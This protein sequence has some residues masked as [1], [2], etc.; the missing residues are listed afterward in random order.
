MT[1]IGQVI[2][3][4]GVIIFHLERVKYLERR[5][6]GAEAIS[7]INNLFCFSFITSEIFLSHICIQVVSNSLN[8]SKAF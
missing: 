6:G 4:T 7:L 1:L 2:S 8:L 3:S 5:G